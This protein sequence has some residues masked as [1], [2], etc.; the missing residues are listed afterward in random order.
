M[1]ISEIL[2]GNILKY[3]FNREIYVKNISSFIFYE[4]ALFE[5]NDVGLYISFT[6]YF[7]F[8]ICNSKINL[9]IYQNDTYSVIGKMYYFDGKYRISKESN[10][11]NLI[12]INYVLKYINKNHYLIWVLEQ[13][14]KIKE[15]SNILG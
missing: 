5:E 7:E 9:I 6:P 15:R 14:F 3:N 13:L 12:I 11:N 4:C 1:N 8:N 10:F 2:L